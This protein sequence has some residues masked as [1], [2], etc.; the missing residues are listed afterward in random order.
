MRSVPPTRVGNEHSTRPDLQAQS[1]HV[2]LAFSNSPRPSHTPAVRASGKIN[3]SHPPSPLIN[4][5]IPAPH[6]FL[7]SLASILVHELPEH[8]LPA[9]RST[10]IR[11]QRK[12]DNMEVVRLLEHYVLRRGVC[13]V[14]GSIYDTAWVSM[15]SKYVKGRT[16]WLFPESFTCI[17]SFQS[18]SGGWEG[19]DPV[20][21]LVN[22]LASLLALKRHLKVDDVAPEE[23]LPQRIASATDFLTQKLSELDPGLTDGAAFEVL[24]PSM[25]DL[26]EIEGVQLRFAEWDYL[27]E[28]NQRRMAKINFSA[29]HENPQSILHSLESFMGLVDFDQLGQYL[30]D[31]GMMGSPASTAA[32]LMNASKWDE[33]AEGYLK[34]AVENGRRI[35]DGMVTTVFPMS[36]FEFA[37]VLDAMAPG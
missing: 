36:T 20:D 33:A 24:I 13:S 16:V 34:E 22:T 11:E 19:G 4:P 29:L 3:F 1:R 31:G 8:R 5:R 9:L 7:S 32:Y 23:N 21:E 14:S 30:K 26:L 17:C 2:T 6:Q 12:K 15:V 25:L 28:R 27:R 10:M 18:E 35:A 37:W